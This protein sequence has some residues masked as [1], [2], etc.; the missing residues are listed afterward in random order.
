MHSLKIL[1]FIFISEGSFGQ[2]NVILPENM[3]NGT[4]GNNGDA[5]ATWEI[6]NRFENDS[7]SMSGTG[8]M[9]NTSPS[10]YPGA[11]GTWNTML[12]STGESFII[13]G[14]DV[15]GYSNLK[16]SFGIRK[17]T[18][19]ED[20]SGMRVESSPDGINWASLPISLPTGSGTAGWHYIQANGIIQASSTLSIRFT[21]LNAIEFRL[22]DIKL[23]GMLPCSTT[24]ASFI[25]TT[26]PV[27]TQVRVNGSGFA[28]AT[29][30]CFN[31]VA[32]GS[33]QV[34][35]DTLILASVPVGASTGPIMVVTNCTMTSPEDF[36]VIGSSCALNGSNLIL[37]E[38]CDPMNSFETD[39]YIEIFNPTPDVINLTGWSVRA[40][41]NYSEC[42]IWNL[43]GLI[44]AR[45]ALTCGFSAP[46]NGGPHDFTLP[47]WN[48]NTVGSCC[49]FW[50]GNR[51]D[52]AALYQGITK[53]DAALFENT[54]TAWFSDRSLARMDTI[55]GPNPNENSN[56]WIVSA[57]V[58]AAGTFPSSPGIHTTH[59]PGTVPVIIQ[60]PV[61]Q[62]VCEGSDVNF[63]VSA[64]G[65]N[66][67]YQFQWMRLD[68]S[69]NWQVIP[70][71]Y[72]YSMSTSAIGCEFIIS[73]VPAYFNQYQY[74]CK[75][76]TQNGGCYTA[77]NAVILT[78]LPLP[79]TS[80]IFHY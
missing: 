45:E 27:G 43:S 52:G 54:P 69:G 20:G 21:S 42:E 17:S 23:T 68:D 51:R 2:E 3:F 16:L 61:L 13:E 29:Q 53:V 46:L 12:N 5:I 62:Q 6:N 57:I 59:C 35:S 39:R 78:V 71:C 1:L 31:N 49:S 80:N 30:L 56:E 25:P 66:I 22:D 19:A 34:V 67:P 28:T 50:N 36:E 18:L 37:S 76:V 75:I 14:I 8:D 33:F 47:A 79:A 65:G 41:A 55:C 7:L 73:D 74:Y 10:N 63:M 58:N 44:Q 64:N 15:S 77:S 60:Q 38:L 70:L 40:I 24:I 32:S 9:R 4:G 48:G 11:S 26:G 72:P